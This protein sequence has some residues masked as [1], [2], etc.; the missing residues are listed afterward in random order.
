[1]HESEQQMWET[2]SFIHD[3]HVC[4]FMVIIIQALTLLLVNVAAL[5][6]TVLTNIM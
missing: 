4:P 2:K 5:S 6:H 1:M 3:P